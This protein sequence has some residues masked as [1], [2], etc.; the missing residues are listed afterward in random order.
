MN[1]IT[2][3]PNF[4]LLPLLFA[5]FLA[6]AHPTIAPGDSAELV[7][8]A[9]SLGIPHPPG[10][11]LYVTL[12]KSV[13]LALPFGNEAYRANIMSALFGGLTC[14]MVYLI[15]RKIVQGTGIG[16]EIRDK[17]S[18]LPLPAF[19]ASLSLAL[20]SEL[21]YRSTVAE[22]Y[23]LNASLVLLIIYILL[24]WREGAC[25]R[26]LYL[27]S[28]LLGLAIGNHHTIVLVI[29]GIVI[30]T[31]WRTLY[32]DS[33]LRLTSH[34]SRITFFFL[35]GLSIYLYLPLRSAIDPFMDWGDPQNLQNFTDVFTRKVYLPEGIER[36]PEL[37]VKQL[38]TFNPVSEFTIIGFIFGL[39]GI[40]GSWKHTKAGSLMLLLTFILTSYGLILLAGASTQDMDLLKKFYVPAYAVFSIFIGIGIAKVSHRDSSLTRITVFTIATIALLLQ[41]MTHYPKTNNRK[42]YLAYDYGMNEL[43]SIRSGAVY[44]SKGEVKTFPL[45]YLQG[46]E[47]Y[48][49]DVTVVT[50]Y[51][52]SQQWFLKEAIKLVGP[53]LH[54][55]SGNYQQMMVEGIYTG[56]AA[57]GVYTGF[58]DEKYMPGDLSTNTQGITFQLHRT[59]GEITGRD[60]WPI[61]KLRG[62][63]RMED[64]MDRGVKEILKDYA[65]SHYNTG[66]EYYNK[67]NKDRALEE[68]EKA[69]AIDPDE[70]DSLYNLAVIYA[71]KGVKLKEAE[72]MALRAFELYTS[73]KDK[74][75]ATEILNDVRGKMG[76]KL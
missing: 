54:T 32:Q 4:L 64:D 5:L 45:W 66:I 29:P 8:A 49:E 53:Y 43:D 15:T 36:S 50:A 30:F 70:P 16:K 27:A 48:R 41:F 76:L 51:F 39:L 28:F 19:F 59:P 63:K 46:V 74:A 35:L 13:S 68:F 21:W 58:L 40:W 56:N 22:V 44:I 61:Y 47:K 26:L 65:S 1:H 38:K 73:E 75:T 12:A 52:L 2:A 71:E 57:K 24:V 10:Y 9:Y 25:N 3:G 11:P 37:L 60:V 7:S 62:V 6:T 34:V 14:M 42:N 72:V 23:T 31:L 33:P 69:V 17:E 20:S 67:D 55:G 18:S